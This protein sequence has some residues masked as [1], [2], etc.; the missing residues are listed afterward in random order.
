MYPLLSPKRDYSAK[1]LNIQKTHQPGGEEGRIHPWPRLSSRSALMENKSLPL[2]ELESKTGDGLTRRTYRSCTD[3]SGRSSRSWPAIMSC[4]LESMYTYRFY[5]SYR[6]TWIY[7][8]H[9]ISRS[10]SGTQWSV[11][12]MSEVYTTLSRYIRTVYTL[13]FNVNG[14]YVVGT[15]WYGWFLFCR[16]E[17]H[18]PPPPSPP[19]CLVLFYFCFH[20][21]FP[22][23]VFLSWANSSPRSSCRWWVAQAPRLFRST[24]ASASA[25]SCRRDGAARRLSPWW[26]FYTPGQTI[27]SHASRGRFIPDIVYQ[28]IL[29]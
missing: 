14:F 20:P 27:D 22:F 24:A 29:E 3:R 10:W 2:V 25:R 9:E 19:P 6:S 1:G 11:D 4:F 5:R 17:N 12:D 16:K 23:F 21:C 8:P 13:M 15:E 18:S 26:V 28:G 7:L